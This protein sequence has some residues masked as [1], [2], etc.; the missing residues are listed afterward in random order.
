MGIRL[1]SPEEVITS[2]P[3]DSIPD[4]P[5][6]KPTPGPLLV[7]RVSLT[8]YQTVGELGGGDLSSL[9]LLVRFNRKKRSN[10]SIYQ[11]SFLE[12]QRGHTFTTRRADCPPMCHCAPSGSHC[13]KSSLCSRPPRPPFLPPKKTNK[14]QL[15][16]HSRSRTQV[17]HP[18]LR[19][20]AL[21]RQLGDRPRHGPPSALA[22]VPPQRLPTPDQS[23]PVRPRRPVCGRY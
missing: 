21:L 10:L 14:P 20:R 9:F 23:R 8:R 19:H 17:R 18:R 5:E 11:S 12:P 7:C 1:D 4:G 6:D 22:R 13:G 3:I 16:T 15:H 2:P